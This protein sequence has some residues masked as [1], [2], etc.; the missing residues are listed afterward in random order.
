SI[1]PGT[2]AIRACADFGARP[3]TTLTASNTS[4]TSRP[5]AASRLAIAAASLPGLRVT[6]RST[7]V[8]GMNRVYARWIALPSSVAEIRK[9]SRRRLHK[10]PADACH[11][12]G[13]RLGGRQQLIPQG[14]AA[15]R[16]ARLCPQCGAA[17]HVGGGHA[18]PT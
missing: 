8:G 17:G 5:A 9:P 16:R 11:R 3:C 10:A 13:Q 7:L 6:V 15:Q 14:L 1:T 2:F 12:E 18:G 4:V